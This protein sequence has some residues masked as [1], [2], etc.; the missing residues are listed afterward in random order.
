MHQRADRHMPQLHRVAWLDVQ[1]LRAAGL[2]LVPNGDTARTQYVRERRVPLALI[3]L[4]VLRMAQQRDQ[5]CAVR[6]VLNALDD[7]RHHPRALRVGTLEVDEPVPALVAP[8]LA[9]D[10]RDALVV[11]GARA[12]DALRER[13]DSSAKAFGGVFGVI[14]RSNCIDTRIEVHQQKVREQR[15]E[16]NADGAALQKRDLGLA[17]IADEHELINDRRV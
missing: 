4:I 12:L 6:V 3:L 10:R 14:H 5:R 7:A 8:A 17:C 15:V 16:R 13:L 1:Q 11:A 2:Q 9:P